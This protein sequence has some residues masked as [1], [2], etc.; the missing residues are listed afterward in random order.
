[1]LVLPWQK[2][3]NPLTAFCVAHLRDPRRMSTL[4]NYG[5]AF[6][7]HSRNQCAD[8]FLK[9]DIEWMLTID[10]DMLINFGNAEWFNAHYGAPLPEPFASFN[11]V[12]RLL[13]AGRTLVGGLYFGRSKFG[14]PMYAEGMS[15]P[16]EAEWARRGPHNVVKPTRWCA[17]G[18]L[19]INRSV[20]LDIE[21]KFPRLARGPGG[22]GGQWFSSSEHTAM[23][24]IDRTREMLSDGQ[25]SGDKA[26]RALSMLEAGAADARRN[27]SLGVGEDA[28]FCQRAKEAGHQPHVDMG[29]IC[30]HIGQN[31][32]GHYN[33]IL[34]K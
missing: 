6:V 12:D 26:L 32:W 27:S 17:T 9:S 21:K 20:F 8:V 3:S 7:A 13:S 29:L 11:A 10:D 14:K 22:T 24:V 16:T 5:D 2:Q 18:C 15:N 30:G 4:M 28:Q 33:T 25:M 31:C 34:K 23:D 19:L 1:M